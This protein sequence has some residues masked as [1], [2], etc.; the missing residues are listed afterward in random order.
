MEKRIY[1]VILILALAVGLLSAAALAEDPY[2]T[3]LLDN[4]QY[5]VYTKSNLPWTAGY[6]SFTSGNA[7]ETT[8]NSMSSLKIVA[9]TA[10][11]LSFDWTVSAFR[12]RG[13]FAFRTSGDYTVYSDVTTQTQDLE[14]GNKEGKAELVLEQ[15]G[16]VYLTYLSVTRVKNDTYSNS[17]TISNLTITPY[18]DGSQQDTGS[19]PMRYTGEDG[20]FSYDS[21]EITTSYT[22]LGD[23][24]YHYEYE[25][26]DPEEM[27]VGG[28][29]R[30][31]ATPVEGKQFYG[32][33]RHYQYNGLSLTS[34][35]GADKGS[36][37]FR[38]N[39]TTYYMPVF[40]DTGAYAA[41]SGVDFY[42]SSKTVQ[43]ILDEAERDSVVVLLQDVE[44]T[45]DLTIPARKTLYVPFRD[46]W[47]T[48]EAAGAYYYTGGKGDCSTAMAGSDKVFCRLTVPAGATVTVNGTLAVGATLGY[49]SQRYQGHVSGWHGRITNNGTIRIN[50]GGVFTALGI[51]EGGGTVSALDGAT[52]RESLIIG[53]FAGGNNSAD[54]YFEN[55]MPFKRF[56]VQ[57]IQC[58]L[59]MNARAS[60]KVV[61][62]VWAMSIYN[63][64]ELTLF[65]TTDMSVFRSGGAADTLALTRTYDASRALTDVNT[66]PKLLDVTGVGLTRWTFCSSMA[67]QPMSIDFGVKLD[68]G[69]CDFCIPY[70]FD[71]YLSSGTYTIPNSVRLLPGAR[72]TVGADATVVVTGRLTAMPG[73]VQSDMSTDRY[74]SKAE[75]EAAG[76]APY[77]QLTVNGVL[78]MQEGS[79]LAGF[80]DSAGG[81][82]VKLAENVKLENRTADL[83]A[84]D[85]T[86]ELRA[87]SAEVYDD[88]AAVVYR[89]GDE[90]WPF[91]GVENWVMQDGAKG[92]YDENTVWFNNPAKLFNGTALITPEAGRNYVSTALAQSATAADAYEGLYVPENV[93]S[94]SGDR[95]DYTL[96][97]R[98]MTDGSY[99]FDRTLTAAWAAATAE[100]PITA[101]VAG[102]DKSGAT[103][104][105]VE[106]NVQTRPEGTGTLI[107][108]ITPEK[109]GA[110]VTA[111]YVY[112]VKWYGDGDETG[113]TVA[114]TDGA[115][116]IPAEAK[117]V[118]VESALAGDASGNGKIDTVD[119]LRMRQTIAKQTNLFTPN[120]LQRLTL[121]VTGDGKVNTVDLLRIRQLISSK[122]GYFTA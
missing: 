81:G 12:T 6:L 91:T 46:S 50:S 69:H 48:E 94:K 116:T 10:G 98:T 14:T 60:L 67:F 73:L 1:S 43:Q 23:V 90:V 104:W 64:M 56:S 21:V 75:L 41:R 35:E 74:P 25:P 110:P 55:Q 7:D 109:D 58:E 101:A 96:G 120:E 8:S 88:W 33:I 108:G 117:R 78:I 80:V 119:L 87:Q 27:E 113:T 59:R 114:K 112:L 115:W 72:L 77:G 22:D 105:G 19:G 40:A 82:T 62:N 52:V 3:L 34:Y 30:I 37:I 86:K 92:L 118:T 71:I 106:L 51:I 61:A 68:T 97:Y 53:D 84:L 44:L 5:S 39:E 122:T 83:F 11:L 4:D 111:K 66:T 65:G 20:T 18:D 79:T 42:D 70:N 24:I 9:K 85:V 13:Y 28:L 99:S 76:F 45:G 121:D 89:N 31:T 95:Y 102:S 32:W 47:G 57:N 16:T 103:A 15:G 54:L 107:Y 36:I 100:L 93:I 26:I 2:T 29:Y 63:P 38:L 17:A 49:P